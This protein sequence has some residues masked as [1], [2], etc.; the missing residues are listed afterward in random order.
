[1]RW[2]VVLLLSCV[3]N[4]AP[5]EA[6]AVSIA[7]F[8]SQ[9][10][11]NVGDPV[12]LTLRASELAGAAVGGFDVDVSYDAT[13]FTLIDITFGGALG[14]VLAGDQLTDVVTGLGTVSLG[15]VSLLDPVTLAGLQTDPLTLVSLLFEATAPGAGAFGIGAA[16]LSD[17]FGAALT[18]GSQT[19]TSVDVV[20]EP[21]L[22][23][24]LALGAAALARGGGHRAAVAAREKKSP[25]ELVALFDAVLAREPRAER[26]R[27]FGY[28]AAFANGNMVTGLHR[29]DWM[30]RLDELG[31]AS[32]AKQ[33]A[34]VFEPTPGG[35][36]REYMVLPAA[37]QG[38]PD[39]LARWVK[40]AFDYT[41]ALPAKKPVRAARRK[42]ASG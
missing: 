19:G 13:R 17:A 38:D 5:R 41:S 31:R 7:L 10:S 26:R 23:W 9:P 12:T 29:D 42:P 2:L 28:P 40:R 30:L 22:A 6:A 15:S 21:A 34:R 16:L 14:D 8:P 25:P 33:G 18:I 1:M 36:M 24:L 20:P 37:L 32:L 3:A 35:P 39:A 11:V 4:L 27:R